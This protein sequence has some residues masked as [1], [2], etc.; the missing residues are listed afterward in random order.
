VAGLG[1]LKEFNDLIRNRNHNLP[2]S[3]IV[4]QPNIKV[5]ALE[6]HMIQILNK[7]LSDKPVEATLRL[8]KT[9]IL[10]LWK[11]RCKVTTVAPQPQLQ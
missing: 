6:L 7:Q 5:V 8:N 9:N 3:S 11:A 10:T 1:K 4:P 2:V